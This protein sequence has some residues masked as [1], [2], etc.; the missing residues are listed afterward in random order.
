MITIDKTIWP[1]SPRQLINS[2]ARIPIIFGICERE[3]ALGFT[4]KYFSG[5]LWLK[6]IQFV[7][8]SFAQVR[9]PLPSNTFVK[10]FTDGFT[11]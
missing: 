1:E 6:N 8:S 10:I 4:R 9:S 11:I 5:V 7:I 2:A 3:A